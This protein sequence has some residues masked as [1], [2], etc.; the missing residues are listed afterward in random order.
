MLLSDD[1]SEWVSGQGI[2]AVPRFS[3][4]HTHA[5]VI[6]NETKAGHACHGM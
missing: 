2:T 4:F 1:L 5:T 6:A 3:L